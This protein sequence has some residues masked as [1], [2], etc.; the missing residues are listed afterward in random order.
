MTLP[1]SFMVAS[2]TILAL[3]WQQ[4][5][6]HFPGFPVPSGNKSENLQ[7]LYVEATSL[8]TSAQIILDQA[9]FFTWKIGPLWQNSCHRKC[10]IS[11]G[12]SHLAINQPCLQ[13]ANQPDETT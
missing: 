3:L 10:F 1:D 2:I 9:M 5:A 12:K 8:H 11:N 13:T 4:K 6:L 7:K